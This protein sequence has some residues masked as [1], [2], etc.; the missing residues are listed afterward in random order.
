MKYLLVYLAVLLLL[1]FSACSI[2]E[3]LGTNIVITGV[4]ILTITENTTTNQIGFIVGDGSFISDLAL[5]SGNVVGTTATQELTNKTLNASVPKGT[6]IPSS[7]IISGDA[8]FGVGNLLRFGTGDTRIY[9]DGSTLRI[10]TVSSSL[11]LDSTGAGAGLSTTVTNDGNLGAAFTT[12]HASASPANDDEISNWFI[13][14]QDSGGGWQYYFKT[15]YIATNVTAG[16]ETGKIVWQIYDGGT[17]N[18]AMYLLGDGT[19]YTDLA[20]Q[21]FDNYDDAQL[22]K[23][24]ISGGDKKLLVDAGVFIQT[25]NGTSPKY[26]MN[27]QAMMSLIAGGVY[28]NRDK[29]DLLEKRIA[30]LELKL[31]V[32]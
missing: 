28:Q 18:T 12:S 10:N 4:P 23:L 20:P 15:Q 2:V 24:S 14:A 17:L 13:W 3:P 27:T 31:G 8:K 1:I 9:N 6:W 16:A 32:K 25:D 21:V 30:E 19:L 26:M 7:W 5:P 22:L 11:G 29:I